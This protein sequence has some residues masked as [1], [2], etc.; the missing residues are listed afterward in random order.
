MQKNSANS[1]RTSRGFGNFAV[2]VVPY[3]SRPKA[4]IA[5]GT[6]VSASVNLRTATLQGV[7]AQKDLARGKL[8]AG[9]L[10]QAAGAPDFASRAEQVAAVAAEHAAAVDGNSRFPAEAI[11]AARAARLMGIAVPR[12]LGGEGA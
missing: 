2:P 8:T 9:S 10:A 3:G 7:P 5:N 12:E 1:C 6:I 4:R 11:A